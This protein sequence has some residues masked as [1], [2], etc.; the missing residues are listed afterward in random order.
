MQFLDDGEE[1]SNADSDFGGA[2][3]YTYKP[4]RFVGCNVV[5]PK[6]EEA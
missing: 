1:L 6:P 2:I 5:V 3:V 4:I